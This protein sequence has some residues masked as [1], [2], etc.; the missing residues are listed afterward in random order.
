MKKL[1]LFMVVLLASVVA[2]AQNYFPGYGC[3]VEQGSAQCSNSVLP[4]GT[5][6]S[7]P[8]LYFGATVGNLCERLITTQNTAFSCNDSL[9][10]CVSQK[11][12][13]QTTLSDVAGRFNECQGLYNGLVPKYNS[14][15]ATSTKNTALIRK[16]RKACGSACKKI[17]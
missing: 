10:A 12:E 2:E 5:D 15:V 14:L 9:A 11:S 13:V 16:L 8:Y 1:V 7:L 3:F 4:C 17:K 6:V